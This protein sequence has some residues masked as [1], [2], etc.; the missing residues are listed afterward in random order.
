MTALPPDRPIHL[1]ATR[2]D[3]AGND[4]KGRYLLLPG[5]RSRARAIAEQFVDASVKT[6]PRGHDL[7]LGRIERDGK[8][9][10][11]GAISTG[12]GCPSIDLIVTELLALGATTLLRV[13]TC[14][15]LQPEIT[16]GDLI[17]A[18]AAV[19]DEATSDHY[20]PREFPALA[21]FALLRAADIAVSRA[22]ARVHFGAVHTKDSLYARELKLGPLRRQHEEYEALLRSGGILASEM[23]CAHLFVLAQL[24]ARAEGPAR[25]AGAILAVIGDNDQPF[26]ESPLAGEAVDASIQFAIDT[27]FEL[28]GRT[29]A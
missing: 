28:N 25:T 3:F 9:L 17:V 10:D 24:G 2:E 14:G 22:T 12:M 13:G 26:V 8:K 5:S 29:A 23:E 1:N 16:T 27:L 20:L 21:S 6:H 4:G 7:H 15:S 11:F 18:T 19:R